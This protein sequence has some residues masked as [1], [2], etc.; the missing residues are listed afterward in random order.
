MKRVPLSQIPY[1]STVSAFSDHRFDPIVLSEV[2]KLKC[3]LSLLHDFEKGSD[4]YDW[5]V[6]KHGI[7]I[8]FKQ[9]SRDFSATYLPEVATE[10]KWTKEEAIESLIQK[11]GYHGLVSK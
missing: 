8:S 6:G 10:Q 1:Y 11:S 4:V 7:I 9:N 5:E 2:D 3:S